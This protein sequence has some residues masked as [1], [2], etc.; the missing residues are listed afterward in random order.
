MNVE[1]IKAYISEI[2]QF[3]KY[4][5]SYYLFRVAERNLGP[6]VEDDLVCIDGYTLVQQDRKVGVGKV[7]CMH[8]ELSSL[9]Y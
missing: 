9:K 7:D 8:A 4:D 1:S 2:P 5:P 3:S 6:K